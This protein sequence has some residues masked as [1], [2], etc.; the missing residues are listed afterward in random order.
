MIS[1]KLMK[2]SYRLRENLNRS[3]VSSHKNID[4]AMSYKRNIFKEHHRLGLVDFNL[5]EF[6]CGNCSLRQSYLNKRLQDSFV[7]EADSIKGI[8]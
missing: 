7:K 1:V 6:L 8:L 2:N 5:R 4:P 3:F